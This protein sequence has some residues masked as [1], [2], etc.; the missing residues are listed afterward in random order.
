ML[1]GTTEQVSTWLSLTSCSGHS[2]VYTASPN[3]RE[4]A[5]V[6]RRCSV[7]FNGTAAK[8]GPRE[9][10]TAAQVFI[11][12]FKAKSGEINVG[13]I[14]MVEDNPDDEA[15]TLRAFRKGG[16][17]EEVVVARDGVEALDYLFGQGAFAGRDT[18]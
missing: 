15:L 8:S 3:L 12:P 18:S 10:S 5:L 16:I 6:W 9:P 4:R 13:T 17:K 7:S 14:L 11:L 1:S 2:N